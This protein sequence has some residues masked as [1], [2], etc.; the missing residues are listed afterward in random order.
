MRVQLLG[1]PCVCVQDVWHTFLPD[2][3]YQLLAYLAYT[4]AGVSREN[5]AHLFWSQLSS[6]AA[7]ANLRK[8]LFKLKSLEWL[9]DF[10]QDEHVLAWHTENDVLAFRIAVSQRDW[11][12]ALGL[13]R[14]PLLKG[15]DSDDD[16]DFKVWLET[17]RLHLEMLYHEVAEKYAQSTDHQNNKAEVIA[18]LHLA[19]ERDPLAEA[20]HRAVMQLE[21]KRG[22]SEAALVQ[23]ERCREI[24][25]KE[26]G[27]EPLQETLDLLQTIE[28]GGLTQAKYALL[29]EHPKAVSEAPETL[30]GREALLH[31]TLEHLKKGEPVLL[32]G[33]GGMGKTAL[34]A[35]VVKRWLE[36][37]P[38]NAVLWLQLGSDS[39]DIIFEALARPFD[40]QQAMAQAENKTHALHNLL[41][42]YAP[43]LLV[44][45]DVW[46]AYSLSK[47]LAAL[48]AHLPV[49]VTSRHR[50][51]KLIKLY[52][53]RLERSA[54]VELLIHHAIFS[55]SSFWAGSDIEQEE[56][57]SPNSPHEQRQKMEALCELL[58]DHAF[59]IRLAG[60]ALCEGTKSVESLLEQI[61]QAPHDFKV[62]NELRH[63]GRESVASLLNVSLEVLNDQEYE[64]FLTYGVLPTASATPELLAR[65][66][67]RTVSDMEN[68][69][70]TLVQRGLAERVSRSGSDQISYRLH[71]LAHSYTKANRLQ[72]TASFIRAALGFLQDHK[73]ELDSLDTEIDNVLLA[74]Q[75]AREQG[76]EADLVKCMQLLTVEGAYYMAR[77]HTA[78]SAELLKIAAD[79]AE[80]SCEA[81]EAHYLF[82]KLGDYYQNFLL[83]FDR[84][85]ETYQR[86]MELACKAKN[87]GREAVYLGLLGQVKVRQ[88]KKDAEEYVEKAYHLAKASNDDYCFSIVLG[89]LSYVLGSRGKIEKANQVIKESLE[90]NQKL[91]Q[92]NAISQSETARNRFF[93]LLN[94]G[95]SEYRLGNFE[96]GLI[97]RTKALKIAEERM[98]EVWMGYAHYEIGEM[99]YLVEKHDL[100]QEHMLCA[101]ELFE[102]NNARKDADVTV[103]FLKDRGYP[104]ARAR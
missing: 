40:A 65:C 97:A 67:R 45:D 17:E 103:S 4:N 33:F 84:A 60:L 15:I 23:F 90:L 74:A 34:A 38:S 13:Y 81:E 69:L 31:Q 36:S 55:P 87:K 8:T 27:L 48:P 63:E 51:P 21:F 82:G 39:P 41:K 10:S 59:A 3:R 75:L 91:E 94:L 79:V 6:Q 89:Q 49:L 93:L 29:L 7:R 25:Q 95:E 70:F 66:A 42:K 50:Y 9:E 47:V 16:S 24:L 20:L 88:D 57:L 30:F 76:L 22:N 56:R 101:L 61:R 71:D 73:D 32:Q 62:P 53:D 5:L 86:A 72:R 100:V 96:E 44:L 12:K 28:Q 26:L 58:G 99:Y 104:I 98:N 85:I 83:D 46:N 80:K 37:S 54:S 19:L 68:A 64:A 14:G 1:E 35:T 78:R 52:V 77:G 92:T 11:S 102:K 18:H 2:R 43:S